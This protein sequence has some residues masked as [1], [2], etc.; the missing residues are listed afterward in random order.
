MALNLGWVLYESNMGGLKEFFEKFGESKRSV[1]HDRL[2]QD[3]GDLNNLR[4]RIDFMSGLVGSN[5]DDLKKF[6]HIYKGLNTLLIRQDQFHE[7]L[8][9][10][11]FFGSSCLLLGLYTLLVLGIIPVMQIGY[12]AYAFLWGSGFVCLAFLLVC[13]L[14]DYGSS[15]LDDRA[16]NVTLILLSKAVPV[17]PKRRYALTLFGCM[18]AVYLYLLFS[19]KGENYAWPSD[20]SRIFT[21]FFLSAVCYSAVICY[22]IYFFGR[23]LWCG[24]H[25]RIFRWYYRLQRKEIA[26]R[27]GAV[28]FPEKFD[29]AVADF[30]VQKINESKEE[31]AKKSKG[32]QNQ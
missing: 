18:I 12:P 16:S 17:S 30:T 21:F 8:K 15:A 2:V 7:K 24:L 27:L 25:V 14:K 20:F 29:L 31:S 23:A 11:Q 3:I 22:S 1:R 10:I 9:S 4:Q 13:L 32:E 6:D 5:E 19:G 28:K 26:R